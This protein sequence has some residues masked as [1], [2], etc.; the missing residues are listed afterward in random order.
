VALLSGIHAG[1]AVADTLRA[2]HPASGAA[3]GDMP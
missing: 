2:P 3:A 1:R